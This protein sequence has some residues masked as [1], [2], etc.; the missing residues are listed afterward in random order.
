MLYEVIT[1]DWTLR[2]DGYEATNFGLLS[3]NLEWQ[4]DISLR[5]VLV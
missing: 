2:S 5:L 3:G 4:K 1:Y